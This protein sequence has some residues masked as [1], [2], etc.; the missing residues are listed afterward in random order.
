MYSDQ[1]VLLEREAIR[2]KNET[3][4]NITA[5]YMSKFEEHSLHN[6]IIYAMSMERDYIE[7][8]EH[9]DKDNN[10]TNDNAYDLWNDIERS[11]IFKTP[12]NEIDGDKYKDLTYS[13]AQKLEHSFPDKP[14]FIF[15]SW[16]DYK[17]DKTVRRVVVSWS[18][19]FSWMR[20]IGCIM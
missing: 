15:D 17:S 8:D 1:I 5:Y 12:L 14:R 19:P 4:R 7:I 18:N 20:Y 3:I 10:T 13:I 2:I 6:M 16:Y 11:R 9:Y